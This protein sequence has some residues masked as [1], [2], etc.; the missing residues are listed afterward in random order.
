MPFAKITAPFAAEAVPRPRLHRAFEDALRHPLA[1]VSGLGGCG[2]TTLV[3]AWLAQRGWSH[4]WYQVDAGDADPATLFHFLPLACAEADPG[5]D[6]QGLPEFGP[7]VLP[8]LGAFAPRYFRELFSRLTTPFAV[9]FDDL[10]E[11]SGQG[12]MFELLRAAAAEVPNGGHLVMLCRGEVPPLLARFAA[13]G[14]MARLG[15]NELRFDDEE[16]LALL[17]L[18]GSP[19]RTADDARRIVDLA[20]GWVAALRL[21]NTETGPIN[22]A[23]LPGGDAGQTLFDYLA[24]EVLDRLDAEGRDFLLRT[25]F[26]PEIG[27]AAAE[28]LSGSARSAALLDDLARR[29]FFTVCRP[30]GDVYE[31]HPLLRAF[32]RQRAEADFGVEEV[33]ALKRQ[34]A[35][36]LARDDRPSAAAELLLQLGDW[37]EL[38]ELL[39]VHAPVLL[40]QT[41][42]RTVESWL[43]GVAA[44]VLDA[45]PWLHYWLGMSRAPFDP[46]QA[47]TRLEQAYSRF[48]TMEDA[49]GAYLAWAGIVELLTDFNCYGPEVDAWLDEFERVSRTHSGFPSPEVECRVALSMHAGLEY[50]RPWHP[51]FQ[52]WAD[53]A[54]ALAK[55]SGRP[56]IQ[57]R[58]HITRLQSLSFAL[59]DPQR[60]VTRDWLRRFLAAPGVSAAGGILIRFAL[61]VLATFDGR[62]AEGVSWCAEALQKADQEGI[63]AFTPMILYMLVRSQQEVGDQEAVR[64]ALSRL[65]GSLGSLASFGQIYH[66]AAVATDAYLRADFPTAERASREFLAHLGPDRSTWAHAIV[67]SILARVCAESGRPDEAEAHLTTILELG[68]QTNSALLIQHVHLCRAEIALNEGHEQECLTALRAGLSLGEVP[69]LSRAFPWR[70]ATLARL[71]VFAIEH[72]VEPETVRRI[73]RGRE[74]RPEPPPV[75]LADWPWALRIDALGGFA[76]A[77]EGVPLTF[78]GRT[79]RK[80]LELL[81]ALVVLGGASGARVLTL[82]N[83]L[84]PEAEGAAAVHNFEMALSRLRKAIDLPGAIELKGGVLSLSHHSCRVDVWILRDLA[85]SVE[86]ALHDPRR[87][88]C[89]RDLA[90]FEAKLASAGTGPL[91]GLTDLPPWA[92]HARATLAATLARLLLDLGSA[93]ARRGHSDRA[94]HCWD[95]ALQLECVPAAV[96]AR[97]HSALFEQG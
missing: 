84:W 67:A 80:P 47:Q 1:W 50:A 29:N 2:K 37:A 58:A 30:P 55:Q 28:E 82:Q 90:A 46:A 88:P 97:L 34:T 68:Q 79:Q 56:E 25:A 13:N 31:Y 93:W 72:G 57:L 8:A 76:I 23:T 86:S 12:P 61:G 10:Q 36:V 85:T 74:L 7:H 44:T 92:E 45:H 71:C 96:R 73:V 42:H 4:P 43:R 59:C 41:R 5:F 49:T 63:A 18:P 3:A 9:V 6:T 33:V 66:L 38:A 17:R 91:L 27:V 75:H 65:E 77:R 69:A 19:Q 54:L 16:A 51:D 53:R 14:Q 81:K 87:V 94:R 48:R 83:A 15:W 32:L 35:R 21:L 20:Q 60:I 22:A 39:A 26:L 40:E 24:S 62:P 78:G 89:E 52:A 95:R 70:P 64:A 11:S